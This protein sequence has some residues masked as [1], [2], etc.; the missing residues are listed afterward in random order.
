[1]ITGY[2]NGNGGLPQA[3]R[4]IHNNEAVTQCITL[5]GNSQTGSCTFAHSQC[6]GYQWNK[7]TCG[8]DGPLQQ[9]SGLTVEWNIWHPQASHVLRAIFV[10]LDIGQWT[11]GN[12]WCTW[13][14]NS[15]CV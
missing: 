7:K 11:H 2:S 12:D 9:I 5:P 8:T 1:M 4:L 13:Q 3:D 10:K 14:W 15:N 6:A